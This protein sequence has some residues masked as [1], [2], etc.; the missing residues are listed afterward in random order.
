MLLTLR[1]TSPTILLRLRQ[2][3]RTKIVQQFSPF[4]LVQTRLIIAAEESSKLA[5]RCFVRS[6]IATALVA[7]RCEK[8]SVIHGVRFIP[9]SHYPKIVLFVCLYFYVEWF[10]LLV[11]ILYYF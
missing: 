3:Q 11:L 2:L 7:T 10:S 8:V 5:K 4:Y 9:Y 6:I 1:Q